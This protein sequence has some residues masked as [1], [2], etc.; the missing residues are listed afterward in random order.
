MSVQIV[1]F[2]TTPERI[3]EVTEAITQL[4]AAVAAAAPAGIEYAAYRVGD[5]PDFLLAL[6]LPD[7]APNP[8][9]D[10]PEA[11]A[12]RDRVG[13]WV[14]GSVPPVTLHAISRYAA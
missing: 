12:F 4:F 7:G 3:S 6:T 10:I 1:A 13:E 14:G 8:L 9:L 11:G 5:G 2:R